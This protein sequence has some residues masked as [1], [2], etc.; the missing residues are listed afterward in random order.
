MAKK[1]IAAV[2]ETEETLVSDPDMPG[3]VRPTSPVI[4][5]M[6]VQSASEGWKFELLADGTLF[7]SQWRGD[8]MVSHTLLD[9]DSKQALAALLG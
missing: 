8:R 2:S 9:K 3:L 4:D 7:I 6:T 1:T 5:E